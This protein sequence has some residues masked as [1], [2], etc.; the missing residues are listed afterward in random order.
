MKNT[1]RN[2]D[3]PVTIDGSICAH[4]T[5]TVTA[6]ETPSKVIA[7]ITY[8]GK[9]I[10]EPEFDTGTDIE[11]VIAAIRNQLTPKPPACHL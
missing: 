4:A 2:I 6:T 11:N 3:V 7:T 9:L 1:V 8:E 5:F 10:G